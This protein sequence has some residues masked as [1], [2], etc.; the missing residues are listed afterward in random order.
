MT[1]ISTTFKLHSAHAGRRHP[2]RSLWR[3]IGV[4]LTVAMTVLAMTAL[5]S[6]SNSGFQTDG[7]WPY[8]D[9]PASLAGWESSVPP[10]RFPLGVLP[11]EATR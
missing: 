4:G 5:A 2:A 8:A 3:G 9:E 6:R 11:A 10:D 1:A 7:T